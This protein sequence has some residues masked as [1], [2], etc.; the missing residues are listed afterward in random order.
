MSAAAGVAYVRAAVLGTVRRAAASAGRMSLE[1]IIFNVKEDN[2][3]DSSLNKEMSLGVESQ[4]R[5]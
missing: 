2:E 4:V 3:G 1:D 5:F